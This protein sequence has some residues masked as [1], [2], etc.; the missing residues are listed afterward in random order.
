MLSPLSLHT[1]LSSDDYLFFRRKL[2]AIYVFCL[3]CFVFHLFWLRK[4]ITKKH[5]SKIQQNT[6]LLGRRQR[7]CGEQDGFCICSFAPRQQRGAK[8]GGKFYLV[9]LTQAQE[10][11]ERPL[12]G[13]LAGVL[14]LAIVGDKARSAGVLDFLTHV[15]HVFDHIDCGEEHFW[16]LGT[17][18]K[19]GDALPKKKKVGRKFEIL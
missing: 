7:L 6:Q 11:V 13:G 14:P 19:K 15:V 1:Q 8:F 17:D 10:R 5:T 9:L 4:V 3:F 2:R 18:W 16:W 12:A